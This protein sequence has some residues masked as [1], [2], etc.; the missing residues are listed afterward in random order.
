MEN[1]SNGKSRIQPHKRQ[2]VPHGTVY[3]NSCQGAIMESLDP[4]LVGNDI[5]H[6]MA[7]AVNISSSTKKQ[8]SQDVKTSTHHERNNMNSS[9]N[10]FGSVGKLLET[11]LIEAWK[12]YC[13]NRVY[14]FVDNF[15]D[16]LYINIFH[17]ACNKKLNFATRISIKRRIT[18]IKLTQCWSG[19]KM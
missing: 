2:Q 8:S 12:S 10:S 19:K 16:Y 15:V 9:T 6:E 5:E 17:R 13:I 1:I 4:S 11:I 3:T 7:S 18:V 14:H